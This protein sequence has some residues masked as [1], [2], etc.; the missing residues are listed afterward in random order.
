MKK[1]DYA[2]D[3]EE[4]RSTRLE[5][6]LVSKNKGGVGAVSQGFYNLNP[7][8]AKIV[9]TAKISRP[10]GLITIGNPSPD[11]EKIIDFFRSAEG[12]KFILQ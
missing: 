12:K 10:L 9:K 7:G 8:N 1:A 3:A 6:N 2:P 5:L 4:V 11:V